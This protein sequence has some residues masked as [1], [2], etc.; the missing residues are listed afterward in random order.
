VEGTKKGKDKKRK[1]NALS[2]GDTPNVML[3]PKM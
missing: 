1:Q 3:H 2:H